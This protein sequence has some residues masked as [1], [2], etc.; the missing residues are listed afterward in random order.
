MTVTKMY[1]FLSPFLT[2]T[3]ILNRKSL[4]I[5]YIELK[6]SINFSNL[7]QIQII[8]SLFLF[9]NKTDSILKDTIKNKK[10]KRKIRFILMVV[11]QIQIIVINIK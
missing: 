8:I 10:Y 9:R 6:V 3:L 7:E 4:M 5:V 1:R 2:S 11:I